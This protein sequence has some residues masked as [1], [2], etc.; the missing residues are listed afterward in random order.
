MTVIIRFSDNV[1]TPLYMTDSSTSSC[2]GATSTAVTAG[3]SV[4]LFVF[5]TLVGVIFSFIIFVC[6]QKHR[7]KST[8]VSFSHKPQEGGQYKRQ[9]DE[10]DDSTLNMAE[11]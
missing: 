2:V 7:G 8:S 5:G 1:V 11:N 4:A 9:V 10:A 3:V 6:L